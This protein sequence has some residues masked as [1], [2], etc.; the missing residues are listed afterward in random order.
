MSQPNLRKSASQFEV[1]MENPYD[2]ITIDYNSECCRA[3]DH[4]NYIKAEC[5]S[6]KGNRK[7]RVRIEIESVA[8]DEVSRPQQKI[9]SVYNNNGVFEYD[10]SCAMCQSNMH[11][12]EHFYTTLSNEKVT[13]DYASCQHIWR[14]DDNGGVPFCRK[15]GNVKLTRR[16]DVET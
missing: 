3:I 4:A 2:R 14:N 9:N 1:I 8:D 16:K 12:D 13:N 7:F 10:A 5:F 6:P 11:H 15:C